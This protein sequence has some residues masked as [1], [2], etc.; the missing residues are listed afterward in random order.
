[1]LRKIIGE[2]I[3][4]FEA[5][6]L[7]TPGAIGQKIRNLYFSRRFKKRCKP[8]VG[9]GSDFIEKKNILFD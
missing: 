8:N 5:F 9:F 2:I 4:W 6:L 1:M 7:F 3:R